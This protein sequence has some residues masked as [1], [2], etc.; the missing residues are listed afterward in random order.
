MPWQRKNRNARAETAGR[1]SEV[2]RDSQHESHFG[3]QYTEDTL[4]EMLLGQQDSRGRVTGAKSD[5]VYSLFE[6]REGVRLASMYRRL[7]HTVFLS[8]ILNRVSK[9]MSR[10]M[11]LAEVRQNHGW[12]VLD[13]IYTGS[14][15]NDSTNGAKVEKFLA[16]LQWNQNLCRALSSIQKRPQFQQV[17]ARMQ[18][19]KA[20]EHSNYL[21][22]PLYT[23][24]DLKVVGMVVKV[25]AAIRIHRDKLS[26]T[27]AFE[28]VLQCGGM[29]GVI[30]FG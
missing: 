27:E 26:E 7:M 20:L 19:N 6:R 29:N 22:R 16:L 2:P 14:P 15:R 4:Q 9:G 21:P 8:A 17:W 3:I 18:E 23:G 5:F 11:A 25:F 12:N 24:L 28:R 1:A 30:F 13:F 10:Q